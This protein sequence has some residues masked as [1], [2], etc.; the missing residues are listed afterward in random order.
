[1]NL[2]R[3]AALAAW[4][5]V[6][7]MSETSGSPDSDLV[8]SLYSD[9]FK[10]QLVRS[11]L[12]L[13]LF[14]PLADGPADADAIAT[15][16][17]CSAVGVHAL[18]EYL[19]DLHLLER[20]GDAYALTPTTATFLVRGRPSYAGDWILME[21][22]PE[23]WD[24]ILQALRSGS[25]AHPA[26]PWAQDAWLES[27]RAPRLDESLEM[28]RAV[29]IEPGSHTRLRILD[30][31]CGC[32]VKS[33]VL[34]QVDSAVHV[35][36]VDS[37]EVL[38]VTRDLAGRLGVLSQVTFRPG[39]LHTIDLNKESYDAALLGQIT[40]YL[41][42]QQNVSLFRHIHQALSPGGTLVI[43]VF[44]GSEESNEM[45]SMFTVVMWALTGGAIHSAADY[46]RWLAEAGFRWVKQLS[47][48][49]L[50]ATKA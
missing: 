21:T 50:S 36:C 30:L 38:E 8:Y 22:G 40:Y 23:M 3:T 16:R 11:A 1:M 14:S 17:G 42:P 34:A 45:T 49:W 41:T 39:D 4:K 31:A 13:D 37:A 35:T 7:D 20:R 48:K 47:E 33:L 32:A 9:V 19:C 12:L 43:D 6:L 25:P 10:P 26:T 27:Y 44:M 24:E 5:G 29:G 46:R 28:W 15:A 2:A 18:L